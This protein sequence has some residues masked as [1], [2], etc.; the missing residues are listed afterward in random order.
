[1]T[2]RV[3][4]DAAAG[5]S[6]IAMKRVAPAD[7][8]ASSPTMTVSNP[9]LS[10]TYSTRRSKNCCPLAGDSSEANFVSAAS[11]CERCSRATRRCVIGGRALPRPAEI[12]EALIASLLQQSQSQRLNID[13]AQ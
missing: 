4:S 1:M 7:A 12:D 8:D 5:Y 6:A 3:V 9:R 11:V 13:E 2:A 10:A